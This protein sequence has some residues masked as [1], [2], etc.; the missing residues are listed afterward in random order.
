MRTKEYWAKRAQM[1]EADAQLAAEMMLAE[2][3]RLLRTRKRAILQELTDFIALYAAEE[4]ISKREARKRLTTD[5]LRDYLVDDLPK[6]KKYSK[7]GSPE[8][9]DLLRR[10]SLR[11]R[12]SRLELLQ[13]R[14]ELQL[15][16]LYGGEG[17]M[18][19]TLGTG[20]GNL[21]EESYYKQLYDIA[22]QSL[23]V[24]EVAKLSKTRAAEVLRTK[25]AGEKVWSQRLWTHQKQ[26]HQKIRKVITEGLDQ[27]KHS[28]VM[29][30]ELAKTF[31]VTYSQA[32]ALTRTE[33]NYFREQG[34]ADGYREAKV[35]K[36]EI[37]ATLDSR[38]SVTCRYQDGKQYPVKDHKPG[39]TAPPFHVRCRSTTIAVIGEKYLGN[40]KRRVG[41]MSGELIDKMT[42]QEWY[43]KNVK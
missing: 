20:L 41:G 42:Y 15:L 33:A 37:L 30:R 39:S 8:Y 22:Q 7:Y 1:R 24:T 34:T 25:W 32:E 31:D 3:D 29:A 18:V 6:F 36:Y 26:Q 19:A 40:E 43:D 28:S 4:G 17:G 23:V 9:Q 21:Y 2:M 35:P 11:Q 13:L 10:A 14:T 16:E 27:G 38:T 5:E 12:I